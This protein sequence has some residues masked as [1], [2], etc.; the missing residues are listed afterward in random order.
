MGVTKAALKD[1]W[2]END[3]LR[4]QLKDAQTALRRIQHQANYNATRLS[5]NAV[6]SNAWR[7]IASIAGQGLPQ[8][9]S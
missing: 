3:Q 6:Q 1:Q 2:A 7:E 9:K 4:K 8:K 5:Y